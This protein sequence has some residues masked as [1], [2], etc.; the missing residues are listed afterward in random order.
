MGL[1]LVRSRRNEAL[2]RDDRDLLLAASRQI[3]NAFERCMLTSDAEKARLQVETERARSNLLSSVSHDLKTPLAMIS[4]SAQMLDRSHRK[5]GDDARGDIIARITEQA[6]RI[7]DLLRNLLAMTRAEAGGLELRAVPGDLGEVVAAALRRSSRVLGSRQVDIQTQKDLPMVAMDA[8]L[9][10]QVFMNLF[11]NASKYSPH[12]NPIQIALA[13]GDNAVCLEMRDGGDALPSDESERIFD[14]FYRARG[15]PKGDGGVGLGLTICRAIMLAH[16][17]TIRMDAG[18][19]G[20]SVVRLEL[21]ATP[22]HPSDALH[23]LPELQ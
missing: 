14:K 17:G 10:E 1:A 4:A 8:L 16:G 5:M 18:D 21:P 23:H 15:A 13:G 7:D 3:A 19:E 22:V 9:L 20:E 6:Q 2:R 12:Q 11:E